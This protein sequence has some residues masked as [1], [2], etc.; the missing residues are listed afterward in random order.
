MRQRDDSMVVGAGVRA[1]EGMQ[2]VLRLDVKT[3]CP[4]LKTGTANNTHEPSPEGRGDAAMV[5]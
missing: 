4:S 1:V 3:I 2:G 5:N